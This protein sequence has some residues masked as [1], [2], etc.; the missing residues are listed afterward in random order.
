MRYGL[1]SWF[2][3]FA[4][5]RVQDGGVLGRSFRKL[6]FNAK[7]RRLYHLGDS[8]RFFHV[9]RSNCAIQ[10][11]SNLLWKIVSDELSAILLNR[12]LAKKM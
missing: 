5:V 7:P 10:M 3:A 9:A 6:A 12:G 2:S 1:G 11:K 4:D 8:S